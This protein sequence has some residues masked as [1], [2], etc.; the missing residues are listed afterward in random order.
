MLTFDPGS[1]ELSR[2]LFPLS[3]L[4]LKWTFPP[5]HSVS[6]FL[7]YAGAFLHWFLPG[8]FFDLWRQDRRR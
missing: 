1:V 5:G 6:V 2:Y 7:W 8:L 4:L 3:V